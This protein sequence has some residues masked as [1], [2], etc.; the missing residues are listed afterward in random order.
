[1]QKTLKIIESALDKIEKNRERRQALEDEKL[2]L[3]EKIRALTA[4]VAA[5]G[6]W[7]SIHASAAWVV[8]AS[9]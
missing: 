5:G 2:A 8:L 9:R 1:M 6:T 3:P 7:V 4:S